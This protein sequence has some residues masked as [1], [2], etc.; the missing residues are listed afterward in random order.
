MISR[1][2]RSVFAPVRSLP[3]TAPVV[4]LITHPLTA[5][6][7]ECGCSRR[8]LD[9][10]RTA[11]QGRHREQAPVDAPQRIPLADVAAVTLVVF[12]DGL[13]TLFFRK[14][15]LAHH[16]VDQKADTAAE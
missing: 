12:A 5:F 1:M 10:I 16:F 6:C 4:T 11:H 7:F 9:E 8:R 14:I 13:G 2:T 3:P 15:A